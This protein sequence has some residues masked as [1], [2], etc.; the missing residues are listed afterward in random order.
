MDYDFFIN[1]F[2]ILHTGFVTADHSIIVLKYA[3]QLA[4]SKGIK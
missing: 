1:E 2:K 3:T 4:G